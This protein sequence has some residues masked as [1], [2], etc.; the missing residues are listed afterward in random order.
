M[1]RTIF[2]I[3]RRRLACFAKARSGLAATEFAL[4]APM[5]IALYF[6]IT[7]LCDGLTA[8][9][10]VTTVASTA[11]DLIAQKK[12]ITNSDRDDVFAALNSLMYPYPTN[13]NMAIIVSS[14]VDNGNN[15]V[16]VAWSDAQNTTARPVNQIVNIPT[17]LVAN[18]S[19]A[20]VIFTE[21]TYNYTSPAGKLIF[22][23]L[24]MTDKF[25][26]KPR[27]AAQISRVP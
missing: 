22:G 8:N 18:N 10:K 5:M 7:E 12:T 11:G 6:G 1:L 17:G 9:M 2:R 3:S 14:L 27:Q 25:Y 19:G 15:Q 23:T 24:A 20:S 4:I 21:V 26:F 13:P 16:K